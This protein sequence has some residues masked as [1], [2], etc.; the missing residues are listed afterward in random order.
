MIEEQIKR[1][2]NRSGRDLPLLVLNRLGRE[3]PLAHTL[4]H[5]RV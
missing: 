1:S 4:L 3:I 5:L 2:Q